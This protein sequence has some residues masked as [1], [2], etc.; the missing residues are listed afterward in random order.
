MTATASAAASVRRRICKKG[1]RLPALDV[2]RFSHLLPGLFRHTKGKPFSPEALRLYLRRHPAAR[3]SWIPPESKEDAARL[4][5]RAAGSLKSGKSQKALRVK[6]KASEASKPVSHFHANGTQWIDPEGD[7]GISNCKGYKKKDRANC[8][9]LSW[10]E[11]GTVYELRTSMMQNAK[12]HYQVSQDVAVQRRGCVASVEDVGGAGCDVEGVG[13]ARDVFQKVVVFNP[14]SDGDGDAVTPRWTFI[15]LH[16]FSNK[17]ADYHDFPHYF[18]IGD[19]PVRVVI[20]TSPYVEQSCFKD[21]NIW[22]GWK[23]GWQRIKFQSWFDYI[24]DRGG[25]EENEVNEN[26]LREI[27]ARLHSLIRAEVERLGG[28]SSRI[29]LGGMSQGCCV[30]LDAAMTYPDALGGVVGL[31]GHI[32]KYT[33]LDAKKRSMPL[34]LFHETNDEEMRWSWVRRTVQKLIDAGFNVHS[35][36]EPDPS[37]AG[38]WIQEIEGDWIRSALRRIVH[39]REHGH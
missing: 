4:L 12:G 14:R 38:H 15:Y 9:W 1:G 16:S 20:P 24:T 35:R 21:W 39:A 30:A 25:V 18:N 19:E 5:Q 28:D 34:H 36:R 26:S 11:F 31:V 17:G 29:I 33:P 10:Q 8:R 23:Q 22:K 37:G 32:M 6:T 13:S 2:R 27:R 7:A 3:K